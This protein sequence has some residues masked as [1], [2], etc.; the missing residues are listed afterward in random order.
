M[1]QFR[2]CAKCKKKYNI[3]EFDTRMET[4]CN[5]CRLVGKRLAEKFN[6]MLNSNDTGLGELD[7]YLE[8]LYVME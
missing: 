1:N 8:E 7:R 5:T 4:L 3:N 6:E 2:I